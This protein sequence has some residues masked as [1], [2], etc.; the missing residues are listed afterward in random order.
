M[1]SMYAVSVKK[2]Q[3]RWNIL[4]NHVI[5]VKIFLNVCFISEFCWY[6][7]SFAISSS[8]SARICCNAPIPTAACPRLYPCRRTPSAAHSCFRKYTQVKRMINDRAHCRL[9]WHIRRKIRAPVATVMLCYTG[10]CPLIARGTA[11]GFYSSPG[12]FHYFRWRQFF[13]AVMCNSANSLLVGFC[14]G[15]Y[16]LMRFN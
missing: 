2:I 8:D 6:V 13:A 15:F 12:H 9:V 3:L 10:F 16:S 5:T 4:Y 11:P 14:G 7:L 1:W